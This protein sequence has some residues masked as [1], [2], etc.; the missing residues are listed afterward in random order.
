MTQAGVAIEAYNGFFRNLEPAQRHTL[1]RTKRFIETWLAYPDLRD[2]IAAKAREGGSFDALEDAHDIACDI[3]E[4]VPWM[5][6]PDLP[7]APQAIPANVRL[8]LDYR[9]MLT[10]LRPAIRQAGDTGGVN[11]AFDR[12]R[13]RNMLRCDGELG[14]AAASAITHPVIA[15]EL[16]DGCSVGCWFCGVSAERFRGNWSYSENQDEWRGIVGQTAAFFGPAAGTAFCYWATDPSDNPDY[17][18]FIADLSA[19]TGVLP[20]TTTAAPLRNP[21]LIRRVL[22]MAAQSAGQPNR[23]SVLTRKQLKEIYRVFSPDELLQVELVLQMPG[24]GAPKAISGRARSKAGTHGDLATSMH[25]TIACVTGFLVNLPRRQIRLV[26]PVQSSDQVPDGFRVLGQANYHDAVS[27][28][29]ALRDLARRCIVQSLD[30][31]DP[32]RL[33]PAAAYE[34]TDDGFAVTFGALRHAVGGGVAHALGRVL[35]DGNG[36]VRDAYAACVQGP[37]QVLDLARTLETLFDAGLLLEPGEI[38]AMAAEHPHLVE[39]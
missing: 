33:R 25:A 17:P 7:P 26:T 37:Q 23:F 3:G 38:E 5:G 34:T 8:W 11:V 14:L 1:A 19:A 31:T 20:Q 24:A 36:R 39:A 35:A 32:L 16:S 9:K 28:G 21:A 13:T 2:A 27:F 15:F 10:A 18:D 29:E 22:A 12:W 30:S 6:I 4:I